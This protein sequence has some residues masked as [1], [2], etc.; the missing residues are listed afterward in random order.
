MFLMISTA[1]IIVTKLDLGHGK[2]ALA[3]FQLCLI[4]LVHFSFYELQS[5][6]KPKRI[7][8][9]LKSCFSCETEQNLHV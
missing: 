9:D 6:L 4:L 2:Y 1:M 8:L 7:K 5:K 3:S